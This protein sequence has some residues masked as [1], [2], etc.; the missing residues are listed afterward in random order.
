VAKLLEILLND[1]VNELNAERILPL[2]VSKNIISL[3]NV[4]ISSDTDAV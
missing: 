1:D 4:V 2:S 3:Y